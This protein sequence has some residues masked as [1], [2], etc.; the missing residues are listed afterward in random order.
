MFLGIR[1]CFIPLTLY[2]YAL[3]RGKLSLD[4]YL[5]SINSGWLGH[6]YFLFFYNGFQ[7][8]LVLVIWYHYKP[9]AAYLVLTYSKPIS[10]LVGS[11]N[12]H[13][14]IFDKLYLL[15]CLTNNFFLFW[16]GAVEFLW[17]CSWLLY[18]LNLFIRIRESMFWLS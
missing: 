11:T 3:K 4:L 15:S 17:C 8:T 16:I 18:Y 10:F 9:I 7:W 6:F 12:M 13:G 14:I 5:N 2:Q 1:S